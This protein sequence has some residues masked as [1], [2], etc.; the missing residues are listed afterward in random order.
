LGHHLH[1]GRVLSQGAGMKP[2]ARLFD[3]GVVKA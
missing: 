2:A 3:F 1:P